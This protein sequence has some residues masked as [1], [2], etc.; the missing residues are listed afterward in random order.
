SAGIGYGDIRRGAPE[1]DAAQAFAV[2]EFVEKP[3]EARARKFLDGGD[4]FWISGMFLFGARRYLDELRRLRPEILVAVE[5]AVAK[6]TRDLD[7][8]RLD[9]A[10]FL[11]CP[12][13][14][15]DYAVMERT[16]DASVVA[17]DIGWSD[18][19]SWSALWE[20]EPKDAHGNSVRGDVYLE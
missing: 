6:G 2:T 5:T 17:A 1:A 16:R 19:G 20:L 18:V 15:V 4:Y 8:L 12:A 7:F 14:S 9:V 3:D 13:E 11:R 10:A